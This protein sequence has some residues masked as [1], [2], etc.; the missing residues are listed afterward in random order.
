MRTAWPHT[1]AANPSAARTLNSQR[2]TFNLTEVRS[3]F[4]SWTWSSCS[5]P[6]GRSREDLAPFSMGRWAQRLLETE[7][8]NPEPACGPPPD[9][10][11]TLRPW[12]AHQSVIVATGS[13]RDT[14]Q[15]GGRPG[16][17]ERPQPSTHWPGPRFSAPLCPAPPCAHR[18]GC[19]QSGGPSHGGYGVQRVRQT[20]TRPN[21]PNTRRQLVRALGGGAEDLCRVRTDVQVVHCPTDSTVPVTVLVRLVP[22]CSPADDSTVSEEGSFPNDPKSSGR[23]ALGEGPARVTECG[24]LASQQLCLHPQV[25]EG[26][27]G[28]DVLR[29]QTVGSAGAWRG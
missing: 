27:V 7:E 29:V 28:S 15:S 4:Q 23:T 2:R 13:A 5:V 6:P 16:G 24:T 25:Q 11:Q 8:L 9:Q 19:E 22:G 18:C 20:G 14:G 17:R 1:P 3:L 10:L 26:T 12:A 21:T